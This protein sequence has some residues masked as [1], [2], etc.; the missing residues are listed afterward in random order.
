MTLSC[1][2]LMSCPVASLSATNPYPTRNIKSGIF[3]MSGYPCNV[4]KW[5]ATQLLVSNSFSLSF[6]AK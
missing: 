3:T 6:S 2:V 4:L 5:Y 1:S